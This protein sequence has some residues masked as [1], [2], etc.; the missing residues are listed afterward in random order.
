[1]DEF[2]PLRTGRLGHVRRRRDRHPASRTLRSSQNR[3]ALSL[4]SINSPLR[5]HERF[6]VAARIRHPT[7]CPVAAKGPSCR[8]CRA[9]RANVPRSTNVDLRPSGGLAPGRS[10]RSQADPVPGQ[11]SYGPLVC[12][13][14]EALGGLRRSDRGLQDRSAGTHR[15]ARLSYR[16]VAVGERLR[17]GGGLACLSICISTPATA[18]ARG[19][20]RSGKRGLSG[21]SSKAW[22]P[23]RRDCEKGRLVKGS[24]DR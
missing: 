14:R 7:D 8:G 6:P 4:L 5:G 12:H 20:R 10:G 21:D 15:R 17:F 3:V 1:M 18:S 2:G 9:L 16:S 23:Q 24:V 13:L 11:Q 19:G 22:V